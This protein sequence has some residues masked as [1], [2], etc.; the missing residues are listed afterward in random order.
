MSVFDRN[1][2][3][4]NIRRISKERYSIKR[5]TPS[6]INVLFDQWQ[7]L[8]KSNKTLIELNPVSKLCLI[9]LLFYHWQVLKK[10]LKMTYS[11]IVEQNWNNCW[12]N[13]C[14]T[15]QRPPIYDINLQQMFWTVVILSKY[16]WPVADRALIHL[17][18][19]DCLNCDSSNIC[20]RLTN[21]QGVT[22]FGRTHLFIGGVAKKI[23]SFLM[24]CNLMTYT[25]PM[26]VRE[27]EK[28]LF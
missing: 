6:S 8:K 1:E 4:K 16:F 9:N 5:P 17:W 7:V 28:K 27:K 12:T 18:W 19:C 13:Y 24:S 23:R 14:R 25:F 22:V 15:S 11:S 10:P 21:F 2:F 26:H 20:S 3:R